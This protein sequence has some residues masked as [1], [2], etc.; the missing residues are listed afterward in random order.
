MENSIT[1]Q[2][3]LESEVQ[4][5][6]RGLFKKGFSPKSPGRRKLTPEEKLMK[7][8]AKEVAMRIIEANA[9]KA[10]KQII[11][12]SDKAKNETVSLNASKDILDRAGVG[13]KSNQPIVPIQINFGT[14]KE[15]FK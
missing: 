1:P 5:D 8:A 11:R 10:A 14:D 3:A 12:L 15:E 7:Q 2:N 9:P 13:T 4:R 6:E